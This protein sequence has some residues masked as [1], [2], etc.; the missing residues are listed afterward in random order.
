MK[1]KCQVGQIS[2]NLVETNTKYMQGLENF[3]NS[4]LVKLLYLR[5]ILLLVV[6]RTTENYFLDS[7]IQSKQT[8]FYKLQCEQ[9]F[10]KCR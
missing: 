7:K 2:L 4:L 6:I 5:S 10:I 9:K 8:T 3:N 1:H